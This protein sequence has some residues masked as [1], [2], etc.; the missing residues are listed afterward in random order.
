MGVARLVDSVRKELSS[1]LCIVNIG[2]MVVGGYGLQLQMKGHSFVAV[3]AGGEVVQL[4]Y[5]SVEPMGVPVNYIRGGAY[6]P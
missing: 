3:S 6:E 2:S 4:S 1:F 5:K